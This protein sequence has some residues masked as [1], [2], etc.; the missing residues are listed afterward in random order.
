MLS[1]AN[2]PYGWTTNVTELTTLETPEIHTDA[3]A[4]HKQKT[5]TP[6]AP[7]TSEKTL[8]LRIPF[9]T[10]E[11]TA[12]H[13]HKTNTQNHG[14]PTTTTSRLPRLLRIRHDT[15]YIPGCE[16]Q[17]RDR[18]TLITLITR[19]HVPHHN[20]SPTRPDRPTDYPT[21]LITIPCQALQVE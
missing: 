5:K 11:L 20:P 15:A 4:K 2:L 9:Q 14:P 7:K 13:S 21:S 18:S 19:G 3:S 17:T 10:P 16:P 6:R 8:F 12:Q 1:T